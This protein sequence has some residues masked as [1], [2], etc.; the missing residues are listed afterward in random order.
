MLCWVWSMLWFCVGICLWTV[1]HS[2]LQTVLRCPNSESI[3]PVQ[4]LSSSL[5]SPGIMINPLLA[6]WSQSP[7]YNWSP[8]RHVPATLW[9]GQGFLVVKHWVEVWDFWSS[10]LLTSKKISSSSTCCKLLRS[11][12]GLHKLQRLREVC[13]CVCVTI[14]ASYGFVFVFA[15]FTI[16]KTQKTWHV[17]FRQCQYEA[18]VWWSLQNCKAGHL[19]LQEPV[20]HDK[21]QGTHAIELKVMGERYSQRTFLGMDPDSAVVSQEFQ[22]KGCNIG[23][24]W[25]V[26]SHYGT[27]S[28]CFSAR[29][30]LTIIASRKRC[31]ATIK[32]WGKPVLNGS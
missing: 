3:S 16:F 13:V 29:L 18:A 23:W 6:S 9:R 12:E 19:F 4:F 8:E 20:T 5:F 2:F 10:V 22:A 28:F 24:N 11:G 14:L 27:H 31:R 21:K 15:P 32:R 25:D 1:F 7:R 26:A 30:P 17:L